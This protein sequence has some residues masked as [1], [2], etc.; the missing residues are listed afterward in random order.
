MQM[1][2][3]LFVIIDISFKI[4]TYLCLEEGGRGGE[5]CLNSLIVL[6]TCSR[7]DVVSFQL[8]DFIMNSALLLEV[9]NT[10]K[11]GD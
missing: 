10:S 7:T 5:V 4:I 1:A 3:L 11:D 9:Q 8:N 2:L 6:N